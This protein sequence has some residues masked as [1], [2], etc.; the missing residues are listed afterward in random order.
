MARS[1]ESIL[2]LIYASGRR[3]GWSRFVLSLIVDTGSCKILNL[4]DNSIDNSV[5]DSTAN[6]NINSIVN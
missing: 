3:C 6:L 1:C 5:V 4:I 2:M